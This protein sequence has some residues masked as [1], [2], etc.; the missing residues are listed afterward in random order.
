ML[1]LCSGL[2]GASQAMR[3]RGWTVITLD[4]EAVFKPDIVADLCTWIYDGP[5]PDLIW[6]SPPCTEFARESM[7]WSRT[8]NAPD[9]A[10]VNAVFRIV[11]GAQPRYWILENVRGA[12]PW[13]GPPREIHGPF[14]LWGHFPRLGRP[15]LC[16]R[17]KESYSSKQRAER[18]KISR[19]LSV[20]VALAVE[21][22]AELVVVTPPAGEG[23]TS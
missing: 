19:A 16:M 8:G 18:A 20:A 23:K 2:G 11:A 4:N 14:Y 7:P 5:R 10:L 9:L 15:R 21:S 13:L 17:L 3:E 22:Q 12:M 1:D 6:A